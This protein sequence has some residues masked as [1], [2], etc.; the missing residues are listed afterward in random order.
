MTAQP[1]PD[2][3]ALDDFLLRHERKG[4]L[5]FV[6]CGAVDDGK[7]TL[8]GRLLYE[9]KSLFDDQMAAL[10]ADSRKLGARDE[11]D[12]S[13][14]LDGLS[15]E[16]EQG[17]T[18]DVA[19]RFFN[20]E[21]RKFIVADT[22]G[23]EQYT[24]NMATGASTADLAVIL[25]DARKGLTL[26]TRRHSLLLSMLGVGHAVLVVNKMDLVDW[27]ETVFRAI[28]AD[29]RK[30]AAGLNF[31][32]IACIPASARGGDNVVARSPHID[33]YR[34]PT[35]LEHLEGVELDTNHE[36]PFRMPV[37]SAIRVHPDF[38]GYAGLIAGGEVRVGMPVQIWPSGQETRIRRIATYDGDLDRAVA[39]QAVTLTFDDE[40]DISRGDVIAAAGR[41]PEVA[42]RFRA[43][44][45]W[46]GAD[47]FVS[48]RVYLLKMGTQTAVVNLD[49]NLETLDLDTLE[50]ASSDRLALNGIADCALRLERPL[51]FDRYADSRETGGFILIDRES[52][53]TV[54]M[55]LVAGLEAKRKK[56]RGFEW[57]RIPALSTLVRAAG[58]RIAGR[59][60]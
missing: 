45:F 58:A 16:R 48:N 47:P 4:L 22:P 17:I 44:I 10:A 46:M 59:F 37:Q 56:P 33:W 53:D 24:R 1:A 14:L 15:A 26:Q 51:V 55:G 13:L 8:M 7:S 19:Y 36:R 43:R 21:R 34:G 20:T 49:S 29:Y 23:H 25:V 40:F 31:R 6:T 52:Y 32:Q 28:E 5:R 11:L 60:V 35:L 54:G 38:R 39:G 27:S 41:A 3:F 12:Y 50:T 42:D 9:A 18:I 30:L 2:A 57:P